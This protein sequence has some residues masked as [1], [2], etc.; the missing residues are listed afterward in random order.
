MALMAWLIREEFSLI[1]LRFHSESQANLLHQHLFLSPEA[2]LVHFKQTCIDWRAFWFRSF[3]IV[4]LFHMTGVSL[5][6]FVFYGQ[7]HA[8]HHPVMDEIWLK[9]ASS[10]CLGTWCSTRCRFFK[11]LGLRPQTNLHLFHSLIE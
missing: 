6:I 11:L 9:E 3:A 4:R 8:L 7:F 1:F 10:R 5:M 2:S